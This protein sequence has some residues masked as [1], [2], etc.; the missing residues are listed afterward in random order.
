MWEESLL[1]GLGKARNL[2]TNFN[3][4]LYLTRPES[5]VPTAALTVDYDTIHDQIFALA[6]HSGT[7]YNAETKRLYGTLKTLLLGTP[8]YVFITKFSKKGGDGRS[9]HL[10]LKRQAEGTA[11][12]LARKNNAYTR[13]ANAVF[14]GRSSGYSF[15]KYIAMHQQAH[16]E[17]FLLQEPLPESKKVTDFL[18]GLH[19]QTGSSVRTTGP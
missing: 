18:R 5:I 7:G 11:C 12:L 8:A 2:R 3:N 15:D 6:A 9:A 1:S 14:T 4:L 17:L 19:Q 16:N 13:I 10:C